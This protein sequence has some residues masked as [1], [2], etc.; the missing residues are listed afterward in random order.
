MSRLHWRGPSGFRGTVAKSGGTWQNTVTGPGDALQF[1]HLRV[2]A[3][4]AFALRVVTESPLSQLA[5]V[6]ASGPLRDDRLSQPT[7]LQA[8]WWVL[9]KPQ[10]QIG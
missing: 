4:R 2:R 9:Q 1:A 10:L 5:D 6:A 7:V 8:G 3:D